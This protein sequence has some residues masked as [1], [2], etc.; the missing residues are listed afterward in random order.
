MTAGGH[1]EK[2]TTNLDWSDVAEMWPNWVYTEIKMDMKF[3]FWHEMTIFK[4]NVRKK[5][6][7]WYQ[8]MRKIEIV[9]HVN[10]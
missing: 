6:V 3:A 9:L 8:I 5:I 4:Q 1:L 2:F 10:N 7:Y